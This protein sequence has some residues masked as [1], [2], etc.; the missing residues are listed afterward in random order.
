VSAQHRLGA[1]KFLDSRCP[2]CGTPASMISGAWLRFERELAGCT[3]QELA[4]RLGCSKQYLCNIEH[5]KQRCT[6][7]V[8][9]AYEALRHVKV[10]NG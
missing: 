2:T 1:H 3:L 8:R 6:P 10:T 4:D 5:G 9:L 7:K